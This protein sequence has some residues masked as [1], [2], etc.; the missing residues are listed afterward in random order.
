MTELTNTSS[1]SDR[2][3][4]TIKTFG[5]KSAGKHV[6]HCGCFGC[7]KTYSLCFGFGFY[8]CKLQAM[9]IAGLNY[10]LLGKTQ[11]AVKK[12]MC[13]ELSKLFGN[14]FKY[15]SS[16]KDGIVKDATLF[17]Q[18]IYIIGLND[19]SSEEK[20]RGISD[21]MGILH[22]EAVLCTEDQFNFVLG[23]LRGELSVELPDE[24]ETQWY[25]GSTNPDSPAH[26]ILKDIRSGFLKYV[27]WYRR[28]VRWKG[29]I[30]Y[31]DM[32]T[33]KYRGNETYTLR[34]LE[35]QWV[36]SD[37][38]VY[39]MFVESKNVIKANSEQFN[40]ESA[41]K[42]ASRAIIGLDYGSNHP[43]AIVTVLEFDPTNEESSSVYL[44]VDEQKLTNTAP[45]DIVRVVANK[46]N[47]L[48]N[49][50]FGGLSDRTLKIYIDPSSKALKDELTKAKIPYTN[51]M[52]EH[53]D[54]IETIQSLFS[55]EL[56]FILDT[57]TELINEI[58]GYKWKDTTNGKDEVVKIVDDL[59]DA[60]R[61]AIYTDSQLHM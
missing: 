53:K 36:S 16:R 44:V 18:N 22:D 2:Q 50:R 55:L 47:S 21:I 26:W 52:N 42:N 45:S 24:Y 3:L 35:G 6:L 61:Y 14:D 60:M 29:S 9:G 59:C 40:L 46:Y 33:K 20:F 51:A 49:K 1:F 28:D 27:K 48:L 5:L 34:Y 30:E 43:T 32:L 38:I 58:Y 13:N 10:V 37:K 12:N 23:R 39:P 54:G 15:D 11:Q 7:G 17:G 25:Y 41:Y 4:Y 31:Y 56:L 8:C 57:C 19:K